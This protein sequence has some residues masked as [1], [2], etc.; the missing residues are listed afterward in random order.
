VRNAKVKK[1]SPAARNLGWYFG[2]SLSFKTF[3]RKIAAM[4]TRHSICIATI[5]DRVGASSVC[6][7]SDPSLD[8]CNALL[9]G[10]P[11]C[12]LLPVQLALNVAAR[13]VYKAR[14]S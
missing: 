3:I 2:C 13:V 12:L 9:T 8:L 6:L 4:V 7:C 14:R 10:L 11:K 5:Q 1:K